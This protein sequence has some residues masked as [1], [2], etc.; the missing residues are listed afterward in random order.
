MNWFTFV[1]GT[2]RSVAGA[3]QA[4]WS[5]S[6]RDLTNLAMHAL[7]STC[8]SSTGDDLLGRSMHRALC[9]PVQLRALRQ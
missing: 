6:H 8:P 4:T 1:R 2:R 3:C 7:S 5:T 9:R